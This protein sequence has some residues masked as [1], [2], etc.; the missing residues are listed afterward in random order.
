[1]SDRREHAQTDPVICRQDHNS[2]IPVHELSNG[3]HLAKEWS[4][5][6]H[7]G[8]GQVASSVVCEYSHQSTVD[9]LLQQGDVEHKLTLHI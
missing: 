2:P 9:Q 5:Y 6:T 1:M 8:R 4:L 7:E 3:V